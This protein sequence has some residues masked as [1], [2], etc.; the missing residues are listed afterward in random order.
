MRLRSGYQLG[1]HHPRGRGGSAHSCGWWRRRKVLTRGA[2]TGQ[3]RTA[4][5]TGPQASSRVRGQDGVKKYTH[6]ARTH[7]PLF[8]VT[9]VIKCRRKTQSRSPPRCPR[10]P[11]LIGLCWLLLWEVQL[12]LSLGRS[13]HCPGAGGP[14][15]GPCHLPVS[16]RHGQVGEHWCPPGTLGGGPAPSGQGVYTQATGS[17]WLFAHSLLVRPRGRLGDARSPGSPTCDNGPGS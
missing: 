17:H 12:T 14:H 11:L 8:P 16:G 6:N 5:R 13:C 9:A 4:H 3:G 10:A 15:S 7:C 1:L 2:L